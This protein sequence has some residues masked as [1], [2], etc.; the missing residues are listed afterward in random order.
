M[1]ERNTSEFSDKV[2]LVT[3][4]S[5]GIG[6]AAALAFANA[7][8]HVLALARTVG[9]LEELDDEIRSAGGTAS[10][11]PADLTDAEAIEQLGPALAARFGKL[12]VLI[13]N[14]GDLGELT[15]LSDL[16]PKVWDRVIATNVTANWRLIRTLDPLLRASDAGRALF[17]TSRVGGEH[18]RAFWGAYGASK[19]AL[20]MLA[21][22]Y[23]QEARIAGVRVAIIDPG[24]MR[25][26]MRAQ[27]VPGEVPDTLPSPS[28]LA[29]LLLHA[30]SPAYDGDAERLVFREWRA[31]GKA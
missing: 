6:R 24:A 20:E 29:P 12:D 14:A 30:A 2:V 15:P 31:A 3:G 8:A 19:A 17:L 10:L 16:A 1:T 28:E 9:G 7:G 5:R 18:A 27:A 22:T 4:A 26:H 11:I 23:A 21:K 13:A 25:T